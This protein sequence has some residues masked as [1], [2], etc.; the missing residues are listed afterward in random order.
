MYCILWWMTNSVNYDWLAV[1][2]QLLVRQQTTF[3]KIHRYLLQ[4]LSV[5]IWPMFSRL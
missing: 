4:S 3:Y 1:G 5:S 2:D